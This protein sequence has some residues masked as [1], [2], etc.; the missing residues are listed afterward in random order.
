MIMPSGKRIT[1]IAA[2]A[3][4]TLTFVARACLA[5]DREPG[6]PL[7]IL[8]DES[9]HLYGMTTPAG[10]GR[11]LSM[12]TTRI[13]RVRNLRDDGPGSLCDAVEGPTGPRTIVFEVSENHRQLE[14]PANPNTDDDRDGY[15]NLENWLHHYSD[16]IEKGKK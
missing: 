10:S 8:P 13:V 16:E 14:I 5:Q 15:T 2:L 3:L 11:H 12:P 9:Q 1:P 6:K 4:L 7:P